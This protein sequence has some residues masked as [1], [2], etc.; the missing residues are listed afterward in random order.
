MSGAMDGGFVKERDKIFCENGKF[1]LARNTL[2]DVHPYGW[3][4][5]SEVIKYS[6]NIASAKIALQLGGERYYRT[7]Q[8]FGFG[9]PTGISLPG[10]VKGLVRNYRKWKPIDLAVT[11][12]G[13]SI[14]VTALQL[15]SAIAAIA[16]GGTYIQPTIAQV[17]LDSNG[18]VVRPAE[19]QVSPRRVI[20]PG[21]A[22]AIRKM[23]QTV[24]EDG[25]TGVN[26]VAPGYT[27]A[28]K[29]GTAQILDRATGRYA[30]GRYTSLFTGF[31]PADKP[32]LVM[33]VVVHE[34]HGAIYGGVVAAP[35]FRE[36]A[37]K[38]LPYLGIMPSNPPSSDPRLQTVLAKAV[39]NRKP[40][41]PGSCPVTTSGNQGKKAAKTASI[42][43]GRTENVVVK[44]PKRTIGTAVKPPA[45]ASVK[46][47]SIRTVLAEEIS[48]NSENGI[49]RPSNLN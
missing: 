39:G 23:M 33:T 31:I 24:T 27:A 18:Q 1:S 32:R 22:E 25:G 11:G 49:G 45:Q 7:I 42:K 41:V 6:S 26:A 48:L 3:L 12:F 16:N 9:M 13:Q 20:R 36:I 29:T 38:V 15:N 17:I 37:A 19:S 46:A 30:C 47:K 5:M 10:E 44:A 34:P 43:A 8:G 35:V 21:T 14:G 4:T 28:G 2:N 40:A